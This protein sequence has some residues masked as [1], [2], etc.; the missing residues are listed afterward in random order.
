MPQKQNDREMCRLYL[1]LAFECF[2]KA[3]EAECNAAE[4]L[5]QMGRRYLTEAAALDPS[6]GQPL[7]QGPRS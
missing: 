2:N 5:K 1:E 4:A 7:S 6:L 3:A